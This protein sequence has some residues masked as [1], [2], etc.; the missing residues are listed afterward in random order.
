M[1]QI[2]EFREKKI[3]QEMMVLEMQRKEQEDKMLKQLDADRKK[4]K[5]LEKQKQRVAE[6]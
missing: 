5:Y 4:Q 6:F 2:E 1:E 3:H